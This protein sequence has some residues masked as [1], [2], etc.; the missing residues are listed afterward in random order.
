MGVYID[1]NKLLIIREP[2]TICSDLSEKVV[3]NLKDKINSI[4]SHDEFLPDYTIQN[5]ISRLLF[6]YKHGND[7]HEHRKQ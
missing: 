5:A 3:N 7:I 2:K 4:I 6:K 1:D